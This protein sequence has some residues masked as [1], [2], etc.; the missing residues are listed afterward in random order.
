MAHLLE[1]AVFRCEFAQDI[2]RSRLDR[3]SDQRCV[4]LDDIEFGNRGQCQPGTALLVSNCNSLFKPLARIEIGATDKGG[5]HRY[6]GVSYKG[7][8]LP[9]CRSKRGQRS[10]RTHLLNCRGGD[11]VPISERSASQTLPAWDRIG[12]RVVTVGGKQLLSGE[13]D[14]PLIPKCTDQYPR[15]Q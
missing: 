8:Q 4:G 7:F 15:A 12:A 10:C 9:Q 5:E 14:Q 2:G 1:H 3:T 11:P 13:H 6:R